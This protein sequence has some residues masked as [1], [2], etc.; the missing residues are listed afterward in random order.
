MHSVSDLSIIEAHQSKEGHF[1]T[2]IL[3]EMSL[4]LYAELCPQIPLYL[5]DT[6]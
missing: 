3:G 5:A 4:D 2:C 6:I 1:Q